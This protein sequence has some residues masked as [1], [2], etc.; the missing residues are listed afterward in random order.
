MNRALYLKGR[1]PP[2]QWKRLSWLVRSLTAVIVRP[3]VLALKALP[4]VALLEIKERLAI[5]RKMDYARHDIL[6]SVESLTEYASRLHSSKKEPETVDWIETFFEAGDVFY[7][8][9]ANVGAYSLIASKAHR[10]AVTVYAFEPAFP[11][12]V[13]LCKN[14]GLN[15]CQE[16]IIPLQIALFHVTGVDT[17]NYH[18][19]APGG[20][21][22]M[23][24][25]SLGR[26]KAGFEPVLRQ[27]VLAY[28]IDDLMEQFNIPLPNHMK[29]DVDGTE[30]RVLEGADRA[31][32]SPR[33][34]Q[35]GR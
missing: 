17:L 10:G 28:R 15:G 13:Q 20:S 26:G 12:F 32:S 24:G 6:M 31:L 23:L 21:L 18:D 5:V 25:D 22:H 7:D 35:P 11:T 3:L 30:I 16:S 2:D 29:I 27:R 4:D 34:V 33:V 14:I 9:G 1:L 8:I 19:V